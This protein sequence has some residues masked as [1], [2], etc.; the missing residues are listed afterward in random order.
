MPLDCTFLSL[1][2]HRFEFLYVVFI[3]SDKLEFVNKK[4]LNNLKIFLNFTKSKMVCEYRQ[5]IKDNLKK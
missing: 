5:K 1:R 3:I 4:N 2:I